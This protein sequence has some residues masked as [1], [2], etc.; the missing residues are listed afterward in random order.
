VEKGRGLPINLAAV[1]FS[2]QIITKQTKKPRQNK[3]KKKKKK[4]IQNKTELRI[5][6]TTQ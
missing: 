2:R 1:H 3:K 5:D 4:K 6:S